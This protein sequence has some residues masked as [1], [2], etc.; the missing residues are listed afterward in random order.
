MIIARRNGM[1]RIKKEG[2]RIYFENDTVEVD[3]DELTPI[4]CCG[5]TVYETRIKGARVRLSLTPCKG[6]ALAELEVSGDKP[7]GISRI[8]CPIIAL[9]PPEKTDRFMFFGNSL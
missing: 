1:K 5:K 3:I 8:D 7:L 4:S 2:F 9:E 6:A